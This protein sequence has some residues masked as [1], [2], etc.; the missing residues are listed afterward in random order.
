M[1]LTALIEEKHHQDNNVLKAGGFY[2]STDVDVK[3]NINQT[4]E[5]IQAAPYISNNASWISVA[6]TL[7]RR[8]DLPSVHTSRCSFSFITAADGA[9]ARDLERRLKQ[10]L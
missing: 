1:P 2:H 5:F 6:A 9:E 10:E 3:R 7:A 4:H 8:K